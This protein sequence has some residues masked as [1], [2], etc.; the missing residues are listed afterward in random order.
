MLKT[1]LNYPSENGICAIVQKLQV[2]V[3]TIL[4]G[5]DNIELILW[6]FFFR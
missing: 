6:F 3:G 2:V 5:D 1:L 4:N